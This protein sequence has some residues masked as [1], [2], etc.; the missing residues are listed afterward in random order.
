MGR[1]RPKACS[2][3]CINYSAIT[4]HSGWAVSFLLET[5]NLSH[6]QRPH[7]SSP[8]LA[9]TPS[10]HQASHLRGRTVATRFHIADLH[11]LT[12][13]TRAS[14]RMLSIAP[15]PPPPRHAHPQIPPSETV[16]CP[17]PT[18]LPK[19]IHPPHATTYLNPLRDPTRRTIH[20][21]ARPL[22]P[23]EASTAG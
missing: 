9:G 16:T 17:P 13:S 14:Q 1:F 7:P 18:P 15:I 12:R 2:I 19:V 11:S 23:S 5:N 6:L 3:P 10:M 20:T 22:G 21:C 8:C 4:L